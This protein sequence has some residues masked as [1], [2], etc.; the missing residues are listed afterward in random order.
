MRKL[1]IS[2]SL[3]TALA[4][5]APILIPAS[6]SA[7][8]STTDGSS[9]VE[10]LLFTVQAARATSS[11]VQVTDVGEEA[12]TLTLSGVDP[13]TVFTNRPFRD[14]WLISPRG[15]DTNWE[16]W[17]AGDPPNAVLTFG[18][19]DKAPLTMVVTLTDPSYRASN[20]TLTFTAIRIEREHDPVEKGAN[21]ERITTPASMNS[22]SLFIDLT[23]ASGHKKEA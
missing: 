3:T 10:E 22:V 11:H 23:Q 4:L 20:R 17:F 8:V 6:A 15:L 21:W 14:A 5:S 19:G 9:T 16:T 12:F 1:L 7:S 13:V 2:A 18:H